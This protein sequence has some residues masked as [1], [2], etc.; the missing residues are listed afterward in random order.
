MFSIR[1][2]SHLLL[3]ILFLSRAFNLQAIV[4]ID[5]TFE[6]AVP[7]QVNQSFVFKTQQAFNS[8]DYAYGDVEFRGGLLPNTFGALMDLGVTPPITGEINGG[9]AI[10][11]GNYGIAQYRVFSDLTLSDVRF[12]APINVSLNT[13]FSFENPCSILL[14]KDLF[15]DHTSGLNFGL[16]TLAATGTVNGQGNTLATSS[17][18]NIQT[19]MG[20][21]PIT[22]KNLTFMSP[23]GIIA[24]DV[25]FFLQNVELVAPVGGS[26]GL[27]N[28]PFF[29]LGKHNIF[30]YNTIVSFN[31]NF[32]GVGM[33]IL[34]QSRVTVTPG[35]TLSLGLGSAFSYPILSFSDNT[36]ELYL[37]NCTFDYA[38]QGPVPTTLVLTKGTIYINGNVLLKTGNGAGTIQFGDGVNAANNMN[39][40]ILPGSKMII[41]DGL[42]LI[43]NNV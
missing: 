12:D 43:N 28:G 15:I 33:F 36:S 17:N 24:N 29:F 26:I 7:A 31:S 6:S 37:D 40:L 4:Q 35:T 39:I 38:P 41:D 34:P 30:G 22:L 10:P 2:K 1:D 21:R 14:N 19:A 20:G 23:S 11:F 5:T 3:T 32:N 16:V 8:G 9:P 25:Q 42:T 13:R 18:A 27:S